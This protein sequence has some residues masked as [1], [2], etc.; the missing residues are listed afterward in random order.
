MATASPSPHPRRNQQPP[1]QGPAPPPDLHQATSPSPGRP[2]RLKK[3][4]FWLAGCVVCGMAV[5][6]F[7]VEMTPAHS[8]RLVL[9]GAGY[10]EN[11][12]LPHNVAGRAMLRDLAKMVEDPSRMVRLNNESIQELHTDSTWDRGLDN[13]AEST[14]VVVLAAHGGVDSKGAYLLPHDADTLDVEGNRVRLNAILDRLA[15]LPAAKNKVLILDPTQ[16]TSHWQL[17]MLSNDF[18]RALDMLEDRI[19]SIPNLVVLSSSGH[20]QRSWASP[21]LGKTIFGHYLVQGMRGAADKDGNRRITMLEL[22]RYLRDNVDRWALHNRGASQT[23]VLLPRGAEG[24]MRARA[25]TMSLLPQRQAPAEPEATVVFNAPKL[26]AAWE[27]FEQL[28]ATLPA[29]WVRTPYLW[30]QYQAAILRYEQLLRFGDE[31]SAAGMSRRMG[32]LEDQMRLA[33]PVNLRS[34]QN[35]LTMPTLAGVVEKEPDAAGVA[36]VDLLLKELWEAASLDDAREKWL[37]T[38]QKAREAKPPRPVPRRELITL[39]LARAALGP[40]GVGR[41]AP[42]LSLLRELD[43]PLPAEA[44]FVV[45]LHRDLPVSDASPEFKQLVMLAVR[46]RLL[47]ERAALSVR[48]GVHPYSESIYPWIE[49]RLLAA[50]QQRQQGQDLLFSSSAKDWEQARQRLQTAEA[51]YTRVQQGAEQ[52]RDALATRDRI[53]AALPA[54]SHWLAAHP[55]TSMG[56]K[57]EDRIADLHREV[58]QL[59]EN[60]HRLVRLLETPD[61]RLTSEIMGPGETDMWKNLSTQAHR[62]ATL[63]GEVEEEFEQIVQALGSAQTGAIAEARAVWLDAEA[64]LALP[65]RNPARRVRLLVRQ[66]E[67]ARRLLEEDQSVPSLDSH[68]ACRDK[69]RKQARREGQ[70]ALAVLGQAWFDQ[71]AEQEGENCIQTQHRL[72]AFDLDAPWWTSIGQIGQLVGSRFQQL[73]RETERLVAPQSGPNLTQRRQNL[74][75]ADR[76]ARMMDATIS[77]STPVHPAA[78]YLRLQLAELLL[79]QARRTLDDHWFAESSTEEPYFRAAGR[80]FLADARAL[81]TPHRSAGMPSATAP[82]IVRGLGDLEQRLNLPGELVVRDVTPSFRDPWKRRAGDDA[83]LPVVTSEQTIERQYQVVPSSKE[84]WAPLGRPTLW[85]QTTPGLQALEPR[86]MQRQTLPASVERRGLAQVHRLQ[87]KVCSS[88]V[89]DAEE[90]DRTGSVKGDCLSLI[91]HGRFRG[92]IIRAET[93]FEVHPGPDVV[94]RQYPSPDKANV[95]VRIGKEFVGRPSVA[96]KHGSDGALDDQPD[97]GLDGGG[98]GKYRWFGKSLSPGEHKVRVSLP[99]PLVKDVLLHRGNMLLLDMVATPNGPELERY[100]FSREF[101]WKR[102]VE[103]GSKDWKLTVLQNQQVG[104]E[105]LQMLVTLEKT[106]QLGAKVLEQLEPRH[107]WLEIQP[108]DLSSETTAQWSSLSGYPG[109]AWSIDARSWPSD[110]TTNTLAR[111]T[112]R[113]WWIPDEKAPTGTNLELQEWLGARERRVVIRDE[114]DVVVESLGYELHRVQVQPGRRETRACLVVRAR[115]NPDQPIQAGLEGLSAAGAEHRFYRGSGKYTA[116]FW[117]AGGAD[118]SREAAERLKGHLRL[119]SVAAF[120]KEARERGCFL[121]IRDLPAPDPTDVRPQPPLELK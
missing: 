18:A 79:G 110:P 48:P 113:A 14:V 53:L 21:E 35:S 88:P 116:L 9:V 111:P 108:E 17:G 83:G 77:L 55:G 27:H 28:Q 43:V 93:K 100:L 119:T 118:Q 1:K 46:V 71:F 41:A 92:Q 70:M 8:V 91:V 68:L 107:V 78:E 16:M 73:S 4:L 12:A 81:L 67:I 76:L 3:G 10:E 42:L 63:F 13:L 98:G 32:D 15:R 29:P 11:L 26:Q 58:V 20:D 7:A 74:Q 69:A 62:A 109:P 66:H 90:H 103:N 49:A 117:F 56:Q 54:Y 101:P 23:P 106:V 61:R 34:E 102:A 52:V 72:E 47:A 24:E 2:N 95:V 120:K 5:W 37:H 121:E 6:W 75:Q 82:A 85:L 114:D 87:C 31:A 51:A 45:M 84:D 104:P 57:A 96:T 97:E 86:E 50:D 19:L 105:A 38:V 25:I 36:E 89:S 22:H 33:V 40:D 59:W 30:Q 60:L 44:H 80:L 112:I 115:H 64:V 39:L 94:L 65:H 99:T